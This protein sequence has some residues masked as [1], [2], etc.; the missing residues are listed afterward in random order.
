MKLLKVFI[1]FFGDFNSELVTAGILGSTD[2]EGVLAG[3]GGIGATGTID[4]AATAT[5]VQQQ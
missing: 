2:K 1:I 5:E 4:T 3:I